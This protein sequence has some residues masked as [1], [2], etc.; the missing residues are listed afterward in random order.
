MIL[1]IDAGNTSILA[2]LISEGIV[3]SECRITSVY[4]G[5]TSEFGRMIT[6]LT[7]STESGRRGVEGTVVSSSV[8]ELS[9]RMIAC[10]DPALRRNCLAVR[11]GIDVGMKIIYDPPESLGPDRIANSLALRSLYGFPSVCIDFGTATTFCVLDREGTFIGGSIIPG[12]KAAAGVLHQAI[13]HLPAV[14]F[15][16]PDRVIGR[17]TIQNLQSGLYYGYIGMVEGI[18]NRIRSE[19]GNLVNVV[20]TGGYSPVLAPNLAMIDSCDMYLTVKG[21][22][23][24]YL[25]NKK[26]D[27]GFRWEDAGSSNRAV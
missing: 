20:A 18:L 13:P 21:L 24:L 19:C 5:E 6:E 8:P 11:P 22:E 9:A 16:M 17:S 23:L 10:L 14:E 25:K 3:H 4:G 27:A 15:T 7:N 12:I 2:V 26:P 1:A